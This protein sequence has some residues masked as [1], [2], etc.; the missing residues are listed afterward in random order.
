MCHHSKQE[1]VQTMYMYDP[2]I[3]KMAI[4]TRTFSYC[5]KSTKYVVG[6]SELYG[7]RVK[8]MNVSTYSVTS[9]QV[10]LTC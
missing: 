1:T 4:L 9:L 6:A 3:F 8:Y 10:N 7:K 5:D 2:D